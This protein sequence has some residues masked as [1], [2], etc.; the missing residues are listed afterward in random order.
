MLCQEIISESV[1]KGKLN[2][3]GE[4]GG[5]F[6]VDTSFVRDNARVTAGLLMYMVKWTVVSS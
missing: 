2:C 3:R 6:P 1:K 4:V 5:K